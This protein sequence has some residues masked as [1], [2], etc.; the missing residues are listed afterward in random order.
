[1]PI[2]QALIVGGGKADNIVIDTDYFPNP[3]P[4]ITILPGDRSVI[5]DTSLIIGAPIIDVELWAGGGASGSARDGISGSGGAGGYVRA[6]VNVSDIPQIEIKV[7]GGGGAGNPEYYAIPSAEYATENIAT[8]SPVGSAQV[9]TSVSLSS[10]FQTSVTELGAV[11]GTNP[12]VSYVASATGPAVASFSVGS[13]LI[14]AGDVIFLAASCDEGTLTLPT[15]PT[16]WSL[17]LTAAGSPSRLLAY[18]YVETADI[19]SGS[20]TISGLQPS[21]TVNGVARPVS[22]VAQV[23]R[24][25][26]SLLNNPN[27]IQLFAPIISAGQPTLPNVASQLTNCM[28]ASFGFFDNVGLLPTAITAPTGHINLISQSSNSVSTITPVTTL[29]GN[30]FVATQNTDTSFTVDGLQAGDFVVV[31]AGSDGLTPASPTGWVSF[32]S[33]GVNPGR[34]VAYTFATGTSITLSGLSDPS[35]N[36]DDNI[37]YAVLA[38]RGVDPDAPINAFANAVGG[39]NGNPDPPPVTTTI[40]G[41][42][43]VALGVLDDDSEAP[44]V[45]APNNGYTLG[46]VAATLTTG[47]NANAATVMSAYLLQTTAGTATPNG[48]GSNGSDDWSAHTLALSPL[49]IDSTV[50]TANRTLPTAATYT[51]NSFGITGA[52]EAS[53]GV[54]VLLTRSNNITASPTSMTIPTLTLND[55]IIVASFADAGAPNIPTGF[56]AISSGTGYALSWKRWASAADSTI[57]TLSPLGVDNNGNTALIRHVAYTYTNVSTLDPIIFSE[58]TGVNSTTITTNSIALDGPQYACIPFAFIRDVSLTAANISATNLNYTLGTVYPVGTNSTGIS[59]ATLVSAFRNGL[60]DSP[61]ETPTSFTVTQPVNWNSVTVG[62]R[63]TATPSGFTGSIPLP[64]G[65]TVGDLVLCASV[66]DE[67]TLDTPSGLGVFYNSI[68]NITNGSPSYQLS[69]K[70]ITSPTETTVDGLTGTTFTAGGA[71]RGTAHI[72][73]VF[74]GVDNSVIISSVGPDTN[75]NGNPD[76]PQ[77]GGVTVND[78]V[79]AFAFVDDI[80]VTATPPGGYTAGPIQAVGIN[81]NS[82]QEATVMCAYNLTPTI[83]NENPGPFLVSNDDNWDA[84]TIRLQK[85]ITQ[86]F[87]DFPL[88]PG[89]CGGSSGGY[90]ALLNNIT[91]ELILLVGGGGGGGGSSI[92]PNGSITFTPAGEANRSVGGNGGVGGGNGNTDGLPGSSGLSFFAGSFAIAGVGGGG[93]SSISGGAGGNSIQ[94]GVIISVLNP[95][96]TGV[97]YTNTTFGGRG[98][99]FPYNTADIPLQGANATGG[100]IAGRGGGSSRTQSITF[101]AAIPSDCGGAGGAGYYGGGG[102]GP[103]LYGGGGGGGGGSAY[104]NPAIVTI[105]S[106]EVGVSTSPAG[107]SSPFWTFPVAVGGSSAIGNITTPTVPATVTSIGSTGGNGRAVITYFTI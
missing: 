105:I 56:A 24:N 82:T 104:A 30:T 48:F 81:P 38:F 32:T 50:M 27:A 9:N 64:P 102:G 39:P 106:S 63:P 55:I 101:D 60:P 100:Y 84:I 99:N 31:V 97:A 91:K 66:S 52:S 43:I 14:V 4:Q 80:S 83:P 7:G 11:E 72:V 90:T 103:G 47:D 6:R 87:Y 49:R 19:V 15:S 54:S 44:S 5:F 45:T 74:R 12:A 34:R 93:G 51:N 17:L 26:D 41:C 33:G 89:G 20:V 61:T 2:M 8:I 35:N 62:L 85:N 37:A 53:V 28:I 86:R 42:M 79:V 58:A 36:P 25:V 73:Q 13:G 95:G 59:E 96:E 76:P 94:S 98:A 1:M 3:K 40:D 88:N 78:A 69:Y 75:T 57:S 67:G 65:T 68:Q 16:G 46:P 77:I 71:A 21:I 29:T 70:F 92:I 107:K 10:P 23:Y 18:K 22:Y